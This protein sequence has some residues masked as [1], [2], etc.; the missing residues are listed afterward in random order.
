MRTSEVKDARVDFRLTSEQKEIINRAAL[1]SGLSLSDFISTTV[2]KVSNQI[3]E[4]HSQ[5]ISLPY[6]IW[7]KF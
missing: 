1:L 5:V 7:E 2:L 6:E 4:N 3:L